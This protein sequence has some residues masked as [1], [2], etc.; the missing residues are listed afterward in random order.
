MEK[1]DSLKRTKN[2]LD[3]G[4]VEEAEEAVAEYKVSM[5]IILTHEWV[6]SAEL[7]NVDDVIEMLSLACWWITAMH[8]SNDVS[9]N[10]RVSEWVCPVTKSSSNANL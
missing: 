4:E 6:I 5:P 8:P 9:G 2:S 10:I 7:T 3:D 1:N